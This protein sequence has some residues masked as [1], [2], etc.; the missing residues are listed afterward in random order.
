MPPS[1]YDAEIRCVPSEQHVLLL[2][3]YIEALPSCT[4]QVPCYEVHDPLFAAVKGSMMMMM[5]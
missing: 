1:K 3:L 4:G 5:G 2:E